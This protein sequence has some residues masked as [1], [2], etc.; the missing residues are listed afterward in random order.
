MLTAFVIF[1]A[2]I[3]LTILA[4]LTLGLGGIVVFFILCDVVT[5]I[6]VIYKLIKYFTK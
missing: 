2:I 1:I 5:A 3:V 6:F 4:V